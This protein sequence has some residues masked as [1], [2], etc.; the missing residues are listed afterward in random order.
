MQHKFIQFLK[1]MCV[2]FAPAN[3]ETYPTHK[4]IINIILEYITIY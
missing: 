4:V 1:K 2:V 3:G